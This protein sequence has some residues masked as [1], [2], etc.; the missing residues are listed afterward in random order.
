MA[1]PGMK[2]VPFAIF[3]ARSAKI[4]LH[5]A[6]TYYGW[7]LPLIVRLSSSATCLLMLFLRH[8]AS[9]RGPVPMIA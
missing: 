1:S 8:P 9:R 2:G 7:T 6:M 4:D 3:W 5:E